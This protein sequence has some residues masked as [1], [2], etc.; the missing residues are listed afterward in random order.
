MSTDVVCNPDDLVAAYGAYGRTTRVPS[1][2]IY[3][4]NDH[5]FGPDL[6]QRMFAAFRDSG[7]S[8]DLVL[9]PPYKD[10][11]HNLIFGQPM[12]REAVYDFIKR[13]GLPYA[14]PVLPPPP[15]GTKVE[16]AF[17]QYLATPDYEKAFVIGDKGSYGWARGYST[18]EEALSRARRECDNHCGT[19]YALDDTL[20]AGGSAP[21]AQSSSPPATPRPV[22]ITPNGGATKPMDGRLQQRPSRGLTAP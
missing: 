15:G 13:N 16:Q 9:A 4:R 20:A 11:G 18:L 19:V 17:A 22:S 1:L 10:D 6:A 14:A 3:A 2:W 7:A 5:F 12:W 21:V 8:G